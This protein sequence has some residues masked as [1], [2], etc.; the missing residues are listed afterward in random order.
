MRPFAL[1]L[2]PLTLSLAACGSREVKAP[3]AYDLSGAIGGDWG[4]T[5]RLRLALVGTGFPTAVTNDGN[6]PQNVVPD[7]VNAWTFGFDLPNVPAVAGAYQ[8]IV[9]NDTNN[10]GSYNVGES[11]ARNRQW[12]IY[13]AF[14]GDFPAVTLPGGEELLPAMTVERGWNLYNRNFPLSAGNPSPAG[15]VTG[16]DLSR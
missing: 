8:V 13:S 7:G 4:E 6:Q 15:K 14:S 11:F 1:F 5:P 3:D 16:Y 12:L 9:Y 10:T 2:L